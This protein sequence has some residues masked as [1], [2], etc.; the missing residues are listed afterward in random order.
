MREKFTLVELRTRWEQ[1]D[2]TEGDQCP[3][4]DIIVQRSLKDDIIVEEDLA[5]AH[6]IVCKT[7]QPS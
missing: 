4:F 7:R 3:P 5:E 6:K 1:A 2:S